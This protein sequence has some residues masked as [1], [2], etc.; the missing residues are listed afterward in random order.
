[1]IRGVS[2]KP[3]NKG[4]GQKSC[5]SI[6][7][8]EPIRLYERLPQAPGRCCRTAA[9]A[10][11]HCTPA[12]PSGHREPPGA[13]LAARCPCWGAAAVAPASQRRGSSLSP[14]PNLVDPSERADAPRRFASSSRV[15][16]DV[17]KDLIWSAIRWFVSS[18]RWIQRL[19]C[20]RAMW[21]YKVLA[22][23]WDFVMERFV[24]MYKLSTYI[25]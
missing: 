4:V 24:Y 22:F 14:P 17:G 11:R 13:M 25:L 9:A 5:P 3:G 16:I 21:P 8:E 6:G 23:G 18:F 10:P 19:A 15:C 20:W 12:A 7:G 1:M 2:H